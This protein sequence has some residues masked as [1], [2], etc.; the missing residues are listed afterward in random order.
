MGSDCL[1]CCIV[2]QVGKNR[3]ATYHTINKCVL[4]GL[5][6]CDTIIV[7]DDD[8]EDDDDGED[9]KNNMIIIWWLLW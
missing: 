1:L 5:E 7:N 4:I 6:G 2:V 3:V 9:D 8:D